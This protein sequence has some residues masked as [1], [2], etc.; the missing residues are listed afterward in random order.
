MSSKKTLLLTLDVL[1]ME[2]IK[3]SVDEN[4]IKMGEELFRS[5]LVNVDEVTRTTALCTVHDRH[6]Y[7][8]EI[9]VTAKYL[10]FKCGCRYST[11]G[12]I[13]EHEIAA[14]FAVR[15]VLKQRMPPV[16]KRQVKNLHAASQL[17]HG[18]KTSS[19]YVLLFSLQGS[20]ISSHFAPW[21][22]IPY[23]LPGNT[24]PRELRNETNL[25]GSPELDDFLNNAP[26][27]QAKVKQ[28]FNKLHPEGCLNSDREGVALANILIGSNRGY[29]LSPH[30]LTLPDHIDMAASCGAPIFIGDWNNPFL[31]QLNVINQM[32]KIG[33]N[34]NWRSEDLLLDASVLVGGNRIKI[35][36]NTH[37]TSSGIRIVSQDPFWLLADDLLLK[38]Q[39]ARHIQLYESFNRNPDI[40]IPSKYTT[41]FRENHL[42]RLAR[43]FNIEGNV[44]HWD[45]VATDPIPRLYLADN[46]GE[47]R[48]ELRF[49]YGENEVL[50]QK[51]FPQESI[52]HIPGT[53]NLQRIKRLPEQEDILLQKVGSAAYG[54]K[55]TPR[56]K[57]A[58]DLCLRAR[59]H[60]VDFLLKHVPR[61]VKEGIEIYG[62]EQLKTARVNRNSPTISFQVAS[63]IDWFDIKTVV[64]FGELEVD[65][66]NIKGMLRR[67]ERFI[68]LAD[69]TIGEIPEDW[70]ER[71]MHLLAL[72]EE[73]DEGLR[74]SSHHLTLIDQ[75]LEESDETSIDSEYKY[76]R[77][78]LRNFDGIKSHEIPLGFMG[79][80]RPYQRAGYDWLHFLREF[81]FGGCLADDMGLGKTV[82]A[83]VFLQSLKEGI[84]QPLQ[85][86]SSK[87]IKRPAS[88]LVVPRSLL[89]NWQREAQ[90]FSPQ[91][92]ILE[93]FDQYRTQDSA[94]FDNADLVITTYGIVRRDIKFLRI[95]T[96]DYII[97][98]ESQAI[99]NP[100]SQTAKAARLLQSHQRLALTGTPIENSTLELWSLFAFLNPGLLGNI[101]YFKKEF[102]N[103][104]ERRGDKTKAQFLQQ[105][106]FPFIL[107]RT[108]DKVAPEL[109]PRSERMIYIDMEPAQR[110]LYN[111]TRDYYRGILLGMIE[112]NGMNNSRMKILEGLLRLRQISNHPM[113]VDK[114]F[115]GESGKFILLLDT[116]ATLQAEGHKALVFSQ[117]VQMLTIVRQELDKQKIRYE[118]LDGQT[119]NRQDRV[120]K[121]Q[122][123]TLIPFFLISLKAGG[124]GLNLTAA[125]YVI[126][127]DPWWNPAV[128]IQATDRTH[129]IGQEKPVFVY[130]LIARD[131]V[132]EKIVQLQEQKQNLVNQLITTERS[133]FKSLKTEDISVLFS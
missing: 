18:Q 102:V 112:D 28:H 1:S 10:Y 132:E 36:T 67:K 96:F 32:G 51:P 31:N 116:L 14:C 99:K 59:T 127:I 63:G 17:S 3:K 128:E 93:Y 25:R 64:H 30:D 95:Y 19:P 26:D 105:M 70:L 91:L 20:S 97:L 13:C 119:R 35:Q 65:I 41:D 113:L 72:G 16:W 56:S 111:R 8:V 123:D 48:A 44:I 110:K 9:K 77:K 122:N 55:R 115:R 54:L 87:N 6:P 46:K 90:R 85:G 101:K 57:S 114:K 4:T 117:F 27:L 125:D 40:I 43:A 47:I 12:I 106:I 50:F 39:G 103:P 29:G 129:R 120:D 5:E 11:R 133:F 73:T 52:L 7:S 38:M 45:T 22:I 15:E 100:S 88:L 42:V 121:F 75:L 104:I 94:D 107:R 61:M 80:L 126:H 131:S 76:R 92:Q 34:L 23:I 118:Y 21:K 89:V 82:Q 33:L 79:Q 109:P 83:L 53:W 84:S 108:K 2:R 58:G 86:G 124:L 98:D 37:D 69:G 60:P 81:R 130:K 74:L 71:Y 66:K 68:K 62:E 49:G 24:L 78:N